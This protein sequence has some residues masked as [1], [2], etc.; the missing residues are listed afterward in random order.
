MS[1]MI[2]MKNKNKILMSILLILIILFTI[3]GINAADN[4]TISS[5]STVSDTNINI[6][7]MNTS[8]MT[9]TSQ[10]NNNLNDNF[11]T[12][13]PNTNNGTAGN[14]QNIGSNIKTLS[15]TNENQPLT[16]ISDTS[17]IYISPGGTSDLGTIDNPTNW[18]YA[19]SNIA[20]GGTIYFTSGTYTT[21]INQTIAKN[22]TLSSYNGDVIIDA[23]KKGYIFSSNSDTTTLT[24]NGLTLINGTGY[25][26]GS[27]LVGGVIYLN[28]GNLTVNNC[29]FK[30][31]NATNGGSI[32]TDSTTFLLVNG[33]KF[34]NNNATNSAG[35]IYAN[36]K[37]SVINS[38][39]TGNN[40]TVSGGAIYAVK[41]ILNI[42]NGTFTSNFA[43]DGGALYTGPAEIVNITK[44]LFNGNNATNLGG[45]I[46]SAGNVT[47]T[48][49]I[50]QFNKAYN[51]SAI[52]A[53]N[54]SV[55]GSVFFN[56]S[57]KNVGTIFYATTCNAPY[58]WWGT[59]TVS[60]VGYYQLYKKNTGNQ[61]PTNWIVMNF[62]A[63]QSTFNEVPIS[64]I[65]TVTLNTTTNV[66]NV[67]G[68]VPASI[69]L[70]NR[71]VT[72]KASEGTL[73]TISAS[74]N[75]FSAS[76]YSTSTYGNK[77]LTATVD[78]Q[79]LTLN[80]NVSPDSNEYY[81]NSSSTDTVVNGTLAHPFHNITDAVKT[82]NTAGKNITI[83][84]IEG[85]YNDVNVTVTN[86]ITVTNYNGGN[87]IFDAKGKGGMFFVNSINAALTVINLKFT[88]GIGFYLK[89]G[90]YYHWEGGAIYSMGNVTVINSTFYNNSVFGAST[91]YG[92]AIMMFGTAY[93]KLLINGSTFYNNTANAG[94]ALY[95]TN[96]KFTIVNSLFS[97]NRA[98]NGGVSYTMEGNIAIYNS[99]F[100]NNH[101]QNYTSS[102]YTPEGSVIFTNNANSNINISNS[103]L[104]NNTL[105]SKN[106]NQG[107]VIFASGNWVADNNWWGNNTPFAGENNG[108]LIHQYIYIN[109]ITSGYEGIPDNWIIMNLTKIDNTII[110][111][112]NQT[113]TSTGTIKDYT[114]TL[115]TRTSTFTST[116]GTLTSGTV[117]LDSTN[118]ATTT[119]TPTTRGS[120]YSISATIDNQTLTLTPPAT[121]LT[122]DATVRTYG[123]ISNITVKL[124]DSNNNGINNQKVTYKV[125][126]STNTLID[127]TTIT[128]NTSGVAIWSYNTSL[129][130]VGVYTIEYNYAGNENYSAS[131]KTVTLTI[132]KASCSLNENGVNGY[133]GNVTD[134][135]QFNGV[136]G[137]LTGKTINYNIDNNQFTGTLNENTSNPGHYYIPS[138]VLNNLS[139]G[140]HHITYSFSGD[141]NYNAAETIEVNP[142]IGKVNPSFGEIKVNN[143]SYGQVE[144]VNTTITT[145]LSNSTVEVYL[146]GVLNG[147]APISS[148]GEISY[149]FNGLNGE[150][151]NVKFKYTGDTN[152]NQYTSDSVSFNVTRINPSF[153]EIKVNNISYGET[154]TVNTTITTGLTNTTVNVYLNNTLHGTANIGDDGKISYDLTGLNG[155]EYNVKF[156]Y[157]GDT[158]YNSL[159]STG[160]SFNVTKINPTFG[161]LNV[162][163][164]VY[165]NLEVVN[166]TINK[167]LAGK[168]V[169]VYINGTKTSTSVLIGANGEIQYTSTILGAGEYNIVI[170]YP[171]DTNY[172]SQNSTIG[173]FTVSKQNPR[174]ST[175]TVN[176]I[177]FS[178]VEA[179]NATIT[180]DSI[181]GTVN[182]YINNELVGTTDIESKGEIQYNNNTLPVGE[183]NVI[184]E[185]LGDDNHSSLNS[186]PASFNV[187][188]HPSSIT[189][190]TGN[191][192]AYG[193][194]LIVTATLSD[195]N[196]VNL[197]GKNVNVKINGT[198]VGTVTSDSNG[199]ITYTN[200]TLNAGTYNFTF[201][202]DGDENYT[203]SSASNDTVN[204]DTKS[205][206]LTENIVTSVTYPDDEIISVKLTNDATSLNGK[207]VTLN[208]DG[209]AYTNTT[210]SEGVATFII[211]GLSGG[212]HNYNF[213]FAGDSNYKASSMKNSTFL[214]N[215]HS[216]RFTDLNV[217]D[218]SYGNDEIV[219]VKL[220]DGT[221]GLN[222]KN[223]NLYLNGT[224]I[225]TLTT[226]STGEV[227][228]TFNGLTIA[229]YNVTFEFN[230]DENYTKAENI[231]GTFN[232]GKISTQFNITVS[233]ITWGESETV[234]GTLTSIN[235]DKLTSKDVIIYVDG[236][237]NT[238]LQTDANGNFSYVITDL[239]TGIHNITFKFEGGDYYKATE[240]SENITVYTLNT[241][242]S[243]ENIGMYY[244]DTKVLNIT[245]K[246]AN[247]NLLNGKTVNVTFNGKTQDLTTKNGIVNLTINGLSAGTY[248]VT[249][250]YAGDE[251]YTNSSNTSSVTVTGSSK[252]TTITNTNLTTTLNGTVTINIVDGDTIVDTG[253]VNLFYNNTAIGTAYVHNGQAIMNITGLNPG[254][255]SVIAFY[256]NKDP[257]DSTSKTL[258]LTVLANPST[259]NITINVPSI[260]GKPG[261]NTTV[262][263]N[264]TGE[265]GSLIDSGN[266]TININGENYTANV[267]N[268]SANVNVTLPETIGIN[269]I[270][271]TYS[272]GTYV[273]SINST[274]NVTNTTT[275]GTVLVGYNLTKTYGEAA[276][277]TGKL[278]D[279]Y[280]NPIAG[281]HIALNLTRISNGASKIY[282]V[283]T[284][285]NGEFQLEIN[286]WVG[287]YS[288]SASYYGKDNYSASNGT[289]N[290]II[291]E[292]PNITSTTLVADMFNHTVNAGLNF[293]GRL[294]VTSNLTP[295]AGQHIAL[296]LTRISNGASKVY[297]VTTDTNGEF[298]LAINLAIANYTAQCSYAGTNQYSSSM[299]NTTIT[300]HKKI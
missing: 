278:T 122:A 74:F 186:T 272:N 106:T 98:Y 102:G 42:D 5:V 113:N 198:D 141:S 124:T 91:G 69:S 92:G 266:I 224:L 30:D 139:A 11:T 265:N 143:I 291:V 262:K 288:A 206:T 233:N 172:N 130:P 114:D 125:Y 169:T 199:L 31:N 2:L 209:T 189:I 48:S 118:K 180:G 36:G 4:T 280:G 73:S 53:D 127:T 56:N 194:T 123:N 225:I 293:T 249:Y 167:D 146:N 295:I 191:N 258:P 292:N 216:T 208:I 215:T 299:D 247:G 33:S 82:A 236:F 300:V 155:G 203:D 58:N 75:N 61:N 161:D 251:N 170:E 138:T 261:T 144:I 131:N 283:T 22:I 183:Y 158:N 176:N 41:S 109:N 230:G 200:N 243:G 45:A 13:Y 54:C 83:Y 160:A 217:S 214:I 204:V 21:I 195:G 202:F 32:Y 174:F 279:V 72:Y 148:D 150:E 149:T 96:A 284:D 164:I 255:Y 184:F 94:G 244:T 240:Y 25:L 273:T 101:A 39:F 84:I 23:G 257:F 245:L 44:S 281:Q 271:V 38:S 152:Y 256:F 37:I 120:A 55:N 289:L 182:V 68:N 175:L 237:K 126:N 7:Q 65:L 212:S 232:V 64:T 119:Y 252:S 235:G 95:S 228:Y 81:V 28:K 52:C 8:T 10:N 121:S 159:N 221:N 241:V 18:T 248:T 231:S 99:T 103:I 136:T 59:N 192:A 222:N 57:A 70:P 111:S 15:A 165:P 188:R 268:G 112:L 267:V 49:S 270:T 269:N 234:N 129:I 253:T 277:Y 40:A 254:N 24:L 80:P 163:G 117:N 115:P 3:N 19:L 66:N 246:D 137:D 135:L 282:W 239:T 85:T 1:L 132:N 87:V 276:N 219:T 105:I 275:I 100:I 226:N 29:T 153:G 178:N 162:N 110:A 274:I 12:D 9:L 86:N 260:S 173:T 207:T 78:N 17:K 157:T 263:V 190:P 297:W 181:T 287:S 151:Y 145:G 205:T 35:A 116:T 47:I 107:Q 142:S 223:V 90:D 67:M 79:V 218:I 168:T 26:S 63:N 76:T 77:I 213:T 104:V 50:F 242:I 294:Y 166:T 147:T 93:P 154:E 227:T 88:N 193:E 14:T 128:T 156:E 89:D 60:S 20:N 220:T 6:S 197:P 185:Y 140:T 43:N 250:T 210:N 134:D 27:N 108:S 211:K 51:G 171:G 46:Y 286:L 298:Q 179:V 201:T 296:N 16:A 196:G 187:T 133:Y 259:S 238:T 229:D 177:T 34:I 62:T 285:T 71:T 97:E 290:S 264:V